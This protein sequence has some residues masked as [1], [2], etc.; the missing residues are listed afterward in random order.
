MKKEFGARN[1]GADGLDPRREKQERKDGSP[2]E[3]VSRKGFKKGR[4]GQEDVVLS[5]KDKKGGG[6]PTHMMA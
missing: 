5:V 1:R 2:F 6:D 4:E 3:P